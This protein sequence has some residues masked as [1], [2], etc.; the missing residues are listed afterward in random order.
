M[1]K[2]YYLLIKPGIIRGNLV[3][4]A[5]GFFL[6]AQGDIDW[7]LFLATMAGVS[8]VIA[9]ACV[10]NN[11]IDRGID[12]KMMRTKTRAL[13]SGV[14]S[15]RNSMVY[16]T[17]LGLAGF[18]LLA[19]FTNLLTAALGVLAFVV[20]VLLYGWSKRRAP[21]GT[22]V[23]SVAGALP[24]VAGY[25]AVTDRLDIAA[26][27]LFLLLVCWQMPHFY[28]IAMY[29]LKDYQAAS[30]PVLPAVKG[31]HATK[32]YILLYIVAFTLAAAAFTV[33]NYTGYAYLAVMVLTG[34]AWLS[35]GL[36]GFKTDND[37]RWARKMFFFSLAVI[38]IF[39]VTISLDS[40]V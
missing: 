15:G 26:G 16:A 31:L 28:A 37:S 36:I 35:L 21:Y 22:L 32:I 20:Y 17:V 34:L 27:L 40:S 14:I 2:A 24:P 3:T 6:A 11:Y 25:S 39:S 4:A 9:S 5:A 18:A 19:D 38:M 23:G 12:A 1:F 29:R 13:V 7:G 8:L 33:F 10:C 30:I